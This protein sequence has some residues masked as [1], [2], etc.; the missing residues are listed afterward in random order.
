MRR[1]DT[2]Y[3][4]WVQFALWLWHIYVELPSFITGVDGVVWFE[5]EQ[6]HPVLF[7]CQLSERADW[8]VGTVE[9]RSAA[10][11]HWDGGSIYGGDFR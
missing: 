3:D 10:H 11:H 1:L 6:G 2:L 4:Q 9:N 5:T 8:L 7:P